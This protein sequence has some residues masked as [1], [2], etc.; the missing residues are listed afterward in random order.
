VERGPGA[1]Y[2][3]DNWIDGATEAVIIY[4]GTDGEPADNGPFTKV[5]RTQREAAQILGSVERYVNLELISAV[6]RP[7]G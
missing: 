3:M 4:R 7:V 2:P 5:V 6:I 1:I